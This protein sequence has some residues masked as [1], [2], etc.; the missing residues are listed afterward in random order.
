MELRVVA[1]VTGGVFPRWQYRPG[2]ELHWQA[3]GPRRKVAV[4]V[5]LNPKTAVYEGRTVVNRDWI[6][7]RTGAGL[8]TVKLWYAEREQQPEGFRHP[9]K[10][11]LD[12]AA[13]FDREEFERF[14][15]AHQQRKRDAILPTDPELYNGDP[16]DLI[17]IRQAT[18]WLNFAMPAR[19][20]YATIK[21]YLVD[22]PGYF[23]DP[24]GE[25]EGPTGHPLPA[26]LRSDLQ[27]FDQKRK[28]VQP[29]TGT[30]RPEGSVTEPKGLKA[31][32]RVDIAREQMQKHGG[33]YRGI[34]TELSQRNG[35]SLTLWSVAVR[36]ARKAFPEASG[37]RDR[38]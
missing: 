26:F 13:Y 23:P 5:Q 36:E 2:I 30:G 28:G 17:S 21:K 37:N 9:E 8:S 24:V 15:V 16:D 32:D 6:R 29:G 33:W 31:T 25:V 38:P 27:E 34:A 22:F 18:E 20:P 3:C 14:Y 4:A 1:A 35:G 7:Q 19:S 11:T 12:R 10:I